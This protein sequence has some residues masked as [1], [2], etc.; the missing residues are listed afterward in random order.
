MDQ[1]GPQNEQGPNLVP[2]VKVIDYRFELAG[3]KKVEMKT[4][5]HLG[6]W[7][8]PSRDRAPNTRRRGEVSAMAVDVVVVFGCKPDSL[9]GQDAI[10]TSKKTAN[11][12]GDHVARCIRP[13]HWE[14]EFDWGQ[15]GP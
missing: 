7:C 6:D 4:L 10:T 8:E 3:R 14:L 13:R 2:L 5:R 1:H 9:L 12:D 11:P 15:G